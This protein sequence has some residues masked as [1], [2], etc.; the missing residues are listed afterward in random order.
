MRVLAIDD[1][2]DLRVWLQRVLGEAG[3]HVDVAETAEEGRA[4]ALSIPYDL[5]L[6]DLDLP[7]GSGLGVVYA[8]RR[9][10]RPGLI[11]ILTGCDDEEV[12]IG[13][14]DAGAD[15]YLIKPVTNNV[16]RARIRSV[17]RRAAT[18]A[19]ANDSIVCGNISLQRSTRRLR[20][21]DTEP[22]L[23]LRE[24]AL[25]EHF[26]A[27]PDDVIPRADLLERVWKVSFDTTTNVVDATLCR[28]RAKLVAANA[29]A[30]LVTVRGRGYV[31]ALPGSG[32]YAGTAH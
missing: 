24:F 31:L 16:L 13:A 15:D 2:R 21:A 5:V 26:M 7:D 6:V 20:I 8:L 25:L 23:T 10:G 18:S 29:T 4:L 11:M 22:A 3:Y 27:R 9:A 17:L 12:L 14:L 28:L 1:N 32:A 30:T 19:P